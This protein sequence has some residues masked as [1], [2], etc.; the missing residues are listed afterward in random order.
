MHEK[1]I[2]VIKA[3][4]KLI[5]IIAVVVIVVLARSV[6]M[7]YVDRAADRALA[8]L[9]AAKQVAEAQRD[10]NA[11]LAVAAQQSAADYKALAAQ[12][13]AQNSALAAQVAS[14]NQQTQ[15]RIEAVKIE[16]LPL[17]GNRWRDLL[18]LSP[19]D[20]EAADQSLVV[21]EAASRATVTA[22][23]ELPTV[24]ANLADMT[25]QFS[26]EQKQVAA[27]EANTQS[28][29]SLA[30][31]LQSQIRSDG[32]EYAASEKAL[33]AT[34]RKGKIQWAERGFGA[35]SVVTVVGLALLGVL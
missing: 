7:H 24:K 30:D 19:A 33:K 1:Y 32:A 12:T 5:A 14:R 10:A 34:A 20:I 13:I 15:Q 4:E 17:V 18:N 11:K 2:A 21:S 25:V 6:V 23:E 16:A 28:C 31:G 29:Q 22:L 35:G 3:H 26:N 9:A 27:C 8:E